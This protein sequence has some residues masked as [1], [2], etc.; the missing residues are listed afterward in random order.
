[1]IKLVRCQ[2]HYLL[3]I[4]PLVGAVGCNSSYC[5]FSDS[6]NVI[7]TSFKS[8]HTVISIRQAFQDMHSQKR[9]PH[10]D[11]SSNTIQVNIS[12]TAWS[13]MA[14]YVFSGPERTYVPRTVHAV[15]YPSKS[16][17]CPRTVSRN[18]AAF[19][20]VSLASLASCMKCRAETLYRTAMWHVTS[21]RIFPTLYSP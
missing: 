14:H 5:G 2:Y 17:E 4:T 3:L 1:M 8:H 7:S 15:R 10:T 6:W 20:R 13:S 21:F 18:E 19:E 12:N 16:F 11:C 9:S